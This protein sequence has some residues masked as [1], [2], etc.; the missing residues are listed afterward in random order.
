MLVEIHALHL[1]LLVTRVEHVLVMAILVQHCLC[2]G[3]TL[4]VHVFAHLLI[5]LVQVVVL[6][7]IVSI[8]GN[9]LLVSLD[10]KAILYVLRS[11]MLGIVHMVLALVAR[12]L[13]VLLIIILLVIV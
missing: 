8:L 5:R 1:N 10:I 3:L 4:M 13:D 12:C 6:S 2:L 9:L 11:E 7:M